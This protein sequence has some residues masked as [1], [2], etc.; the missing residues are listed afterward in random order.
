MSRRVVISGMGLVTPLG[1]DAPSTWEALLAGKSGVGPI[2]KFDAS[3]LQARIA[4]EV[5]DFDPLQHIDKK[6]ARKMDAFTHFAVVAAKE[7][8]G[9]SGF[10]IDDENANR[11]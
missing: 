8:L 3:N 1:L 4:G 10:E 2:T 7:A 6:E 9:D 11:F 5:R